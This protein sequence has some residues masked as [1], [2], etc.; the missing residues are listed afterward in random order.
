MDSTSK[1]KLIES[2]LTRQRLT[3]PH[4]LAFSWVYGK[5]AEGG[6]KR[7]LDFG[8]RYSL[9]PTL[10]SLYGHRVTAVDRDP[11]VI[12]SQRKMGADHGVEIDALKWTIDD[13]PLPEPFD[14]AVACWAVQHNDLG[15]QTR[16]MRELVRMIRPGGRL[17]VVSSYASR[18]TFR[19][20][21]RPDPQWVLNRHDHET[22]LIGP[23]G[24]TLKEW[25][26]FWYRHATYEGDWC[27]TDDEA[28][29]A[30]AYELTVPTT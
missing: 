26:P 1:Q 13:A 29:N 19:Q 21:N 7:V 27:L 2:I 5:L 14:A 23:S 28:A 4:Y 6:V 16:I 30:V 15:E 20:D 3:S 17:L 18:Q 10:L 12:E 9:L 11:I 8:S 22:H 24:A 25:A